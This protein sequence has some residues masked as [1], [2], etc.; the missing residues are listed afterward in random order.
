M[1]DK[2]WYRQ[3]WPWFLIALPAT[4]VIA[5]IVTIFIAV[6]HSDA[7]VE[8]NYYKEGLAIN[9]DLR[10]SHTAKKYGLSADIFLDRIGQKLL[11]DLQAQVPLALPQM[12]NVKL[13]HPFD[14]SLDRVYPMTLSPIKK[15]NNV[16]RYQQ[17]WQ[18]MPATN[19]RVEITP[20]YVEIDAEEQIAWQIKQRFNSA[21]GDTPR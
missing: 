11:V 3:F 9:T 6:R 18:E 14:K 17:D 2:I 8:D 16:S 19:W 1:S 13:M 21:D 20:L 5:G 4:T 15:Q 12:L 7:L 10:K